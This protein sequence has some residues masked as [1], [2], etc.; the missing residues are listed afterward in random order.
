MKVLG[1]NCS[2]RK[3]NTYRLIEMVM[4]GI[5]EPEIEK[6]IITI[7]DYKNFNFC[8]GCCNCMYVSPGECVQKDDIAF[9]Q[10]KIIEADGFILGSPVYIGQVSAHL[11]NLIDRCCAWTHRP[12]LIGKHAVVVAT[13]AAAPS[14]AKATIEYMKWWMRMIGSWVIG[15]LAVYAPHTHIENEEEVRKKAHELGTKLI[16]DIIDKKTYPPTEEDA[17]IFNA[18]KRKVQS[19]G[20]ADLEYWKKKG[21]LDKEYYT[22]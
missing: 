7:S 13:I 20:G 18:I 9:I 2:P 16:L 4:E 11:K 10:K 3:K 12:P 14:A 19:I 5:S 22:S 17:R 15:E 8:L 1:I 21:W 6:E